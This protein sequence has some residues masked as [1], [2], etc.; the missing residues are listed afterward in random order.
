MTDII[1]EQHADANVCADPGFASFSGRHD[2]LKKPS[3]AF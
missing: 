2:R 3:C 1:V